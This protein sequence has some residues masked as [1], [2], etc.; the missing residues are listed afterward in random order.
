MG[1]R[2]LDAVFSLEFLD[3]HEHV[4]L[5]G[6]AGVGKS[7]LVQALGYAAV[8]S[9]HT[10]RFIHADNFHADNFF[11][12]MAQARVVDV[13]QAST[14]SA[15]KRAGRFN[16]NRSSR[17]GGKS[18]ICARTGKPGYLPAGRATAELPPT[19]ALC[20]TAAAKVSSLM[21]VDSQG[22][23]SSDSMSRMYKTRLSRKWDL[24]PKRSCFTASV[25]WCC[26][27]YDKWSDDY[28]STTR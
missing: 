17:V 5:V 20:N 22:W 15:T 26:I 11:R 21:G 2:L 4:L 24:R 9:G 19:M 16:G 28:T 23:A 3:K 10:V 27:V 6:P 18:H 13:K 14:N 7:F 25:H 12:A 1:R 8:R